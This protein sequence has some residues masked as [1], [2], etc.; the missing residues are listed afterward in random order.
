M[1]LI[2]KEE[3]IIKIEIQ[4]NF[5]LLHL[6]IIFILSVFR[7]Q[8]KNDLNQKYNKLMNFAYFSMSLLASILFDKFF[9]L[10]I[11]HRSQ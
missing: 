1:D 8:K 5:G 10:V 6:N 7:Q 2:Y 11:L 3:I 9:K 4:N